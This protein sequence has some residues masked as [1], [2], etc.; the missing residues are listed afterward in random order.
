MDIHW[1]DIII[2]III[3]IIDNKCSD[4]KGD[5]IYD[6]WNI[7]F[8]ESTRA[9]LPLLLDSFKAGGQL[10]GGGAPNTDFVLEEE[11]RGRGLNVLD[12]LEALSKFW[13][14][15]KAWFR[16]MTS[17]KMSSLLIS[18]VIPF[19]KPTQCSNFIL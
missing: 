12:D 14:K 2:I 8:G 17:L 5:R 10:E 19:P 9:P 3:I 16:D 18:S 11:G 7:V 1:W 4:G 13:A 15:V 6:I